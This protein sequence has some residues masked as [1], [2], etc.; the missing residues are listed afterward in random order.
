M[1]ALLSRCQAARSMQIPRERCT[2]ESFAILPVRQW[3]GVCKHPCAGGILYYRYY[4]RTESQFLST[5]LAGSTQSGRN[6]CGAA[7][8]AML[9]AT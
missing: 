7:P 5:D 8:S 6:R 2:A 4:R 1:G 9:N 3:D